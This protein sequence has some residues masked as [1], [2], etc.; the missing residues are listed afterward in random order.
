M[1]DPKDNI[2][3]QLDL[4]SYSTR[5]W[6]LLMISGFTVGAINL[7][8]K[9]D[10]ILMIAAIALVFSALGVAIFEKRI[11]RYYQNKRRKNEY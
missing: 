1:S 6:L 9:I 5:I 8:F 4:R 10:F 11:D 7:I 2:R 3:K